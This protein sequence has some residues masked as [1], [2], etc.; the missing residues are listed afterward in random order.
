MNKRS[1]GALAAAACTTGA[2]HA[3]VNVEGY[4]SGDNQFVAYTGTASGT[5]SPF[6]SLGDWA[7]YVTFNTVVTG[8]GY[9]Y[10]A[11]TDYGDVFG[12]GGYISVNGGTSP[13]IA[14]MGWESYNLGAGTT[15]TPDQAAIDGFIA[16]ANAGNAWLAATAG[17]AV[18]SFGLPADYNGLP[19]LGCIWDPRADV[20][21]T[22]IFRLLI[23]PAPLSA[24]PLAA[25]MMV[26]TRRR[27]HGGV[28]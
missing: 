19:T 2:A 24:A 15:T 14:G 5:T 1:I 3:Q 8:N 26:L 20:N 4:L 28:A 21:E 13:I 6:A 17:T 23:V 16:T 18:I 9:I 12:L 11:V 22:V 27:R 25:G 10:I 7:S